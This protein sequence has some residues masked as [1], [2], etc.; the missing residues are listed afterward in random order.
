MANP[1]DALKPAQKIITVAGLGGPITVRE[2]TLSE[3]TSISNQK[4]QG[5]A[6]YAYIATSLV[7]PKMGVKELKGLGTK[8]MPVLSEII[9]HIM[10]NSGNSPTV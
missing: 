8:A 3:V 6:M 9:T 10:P 1:F 7:T 5:E 2:L 4:D